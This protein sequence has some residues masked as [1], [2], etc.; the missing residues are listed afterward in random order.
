MKIAP[1]KHTPSN[2]EPTTLE[3]AVD[4][5]NT[6]FPFIADSVIAYEEFVDGKG[7]TVRASH[8][9]YVFGIKMEG[10]HSV[11]DLIQ[12]WFVEMLMAVRASKYKRLYW[13]L[14]PEITVERMDFPDG[15]A[16]GLKIISRSSMI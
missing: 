8:I 12:E 3:E 15:P 10:Q 2:L 16:Y 13:R 7:E 1:K 11:H 5:I 6:K 4:Y 14:K 9:T